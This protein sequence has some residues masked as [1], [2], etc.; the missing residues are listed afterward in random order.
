MINVKSKMSYILNKHNF[1]K[2][3]ADSFIYGQGL[4]FNN[5]VLYIDK[6]AENQTIQKKCAMRRTLIST[7]NE[8]GHHILAD[9]VVMM[10]GSTY[11]PDIQYSDVIV[12]IRAV[13]LELDDYNTPVIFD[14]AI[15]DFTN[16]DYNDIIKDIRTRLYKL[17]TQW[18]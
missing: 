1:R 3:N 5:I 16:G 6:T 8:D 4:P 10:F 12:T 9:N 15:A 11:Q 7:T 18:R 17:K 14:Y 2:S 13:Y